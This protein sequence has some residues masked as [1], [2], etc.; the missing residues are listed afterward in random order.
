MLVLPE[1]IRRTLNKRI[2][3]ILGIDGFAGSLKDKELTK[4]RLRKLNDKEI[5][6]KRRLL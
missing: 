2:M 1:K 6:F 4:G 5:K 3:K